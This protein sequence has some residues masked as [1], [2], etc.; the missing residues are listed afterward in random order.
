MTEF[1]I[2]G[3]FF[4]IG[5]LSAMQQFHVMRKISPLMPPLM[6]IFAQV[7]N[8]QKKGVKVQDDFEVIG[9]LLQPFAD[10]LSGMSDESSEYVFNTCLSAV[11]YKHGENWIQFWNATGKVAM[12]MELN[13]DVALLV[14]LVVRVIADSLAPFLSGFLTNASEPEAESRSTSFQEAKTG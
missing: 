2:D 13:G 4:R 9:P 1:E 12:V 10:G 6:P 11:R 7:A 3:K 14:R 8:D 5:K